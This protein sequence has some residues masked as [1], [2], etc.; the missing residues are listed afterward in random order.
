MTFVNVSFNLQKQLISLR[1]VE[2][3]YYTYALHLSKKNYS[4]NI[5]VVMVQSEI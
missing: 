2:Y 4:S 1:N 5:V 3:V